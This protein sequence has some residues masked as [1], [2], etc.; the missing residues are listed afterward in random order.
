MRWIKN[1]MKEIFLLL[2]SRYTTEDGD[3]LSM[4]E[5]LFI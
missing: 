4:N 1:V 5:G 2:N 3:N